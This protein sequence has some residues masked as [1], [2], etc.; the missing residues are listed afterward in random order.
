MESR[1]RRPRRLAPSFASQIARSITGSVIGSITTSITTVV[2]AP[3]TRAVAVAASLTALLLLGGAG[4]T[5]CSSRSRGAPAAAMKPDSAYADYWDARDAALAGC[6]QGDAAACLRAAFG[7]YA[8]GDADRW[9]VIRKGCELGE[10]LVCE[11]GCILGGPETNAGFVLA[12]HQPNADL[13]VCQELER[14][15]RD[16]ALPALQATCRQRQLLKPAA[17][18]D[19]IAQACAA[20]SSDERCQAA[21]ALREGSQ[22]PDEENRAGSPLRLRACQGGWPRACATELSLRCRRLYQTRDR[23]ELWAVEDRACTEEELARVAKTES[24]RAL[25]EET[26]RRCKG[27]EQEA[28]VSLPELPQASAAALCARGYRPACQRIIARAGAA[29]EQ[30]LGALTDPLSG[31]LAGA[32]AC[33]VGDKRACAD[34]HAELLRPF[35]GVEE[36]AEDPGFDEDDA[37]GSRR[38]ARR[39]ALPQNVAREQA[40]QL[41]LRLCGTAPWACSIAA[42]LT[43]ESWRERFIVVDGEPASC[44]QAISR[45]RQ[46][47]KLPP[48]AAGPELARA[49]AGCQRHL[50]EPHRTC[51]AR[52]ERMAELFN[53]QEALRPDEVLAA[54]AGRLALQAVEHFRSKRKLPAAWPGKAKREPCCGEACAPPPPPGPD[55]GEVV[56][57]NGDVGVTQGDAEGEAMAEHAATAGYFDR[58]APEEGW[59]APTPRS[60]SFGDDTVS[61]D[62]RYPWAQLLLAR[63]SD[64]VV[65]SARGRRTCD[66]PEVIVEERWRLIDGEPSRTKQ[67]R[68]TS[69]QPPR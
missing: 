44:E 57:E 60:Y 61:L 23:D 25:I 9:A 14:M 18:N 48:L 10:A 35:E 7:P 59:N 34:L 13:Y 67:T 32:P 30:I 63:E 53:C 31:P 62:E 1:G 12:C 43:S 22:A 19:V 29:P 39:A 16:A 40:N 20:S 46:L 55:F 54:E 58:D 69:Q 49:L 41:L 27:G 64:V 68:Q 4:L 33:L 52:A 38:R 3:V 45:A 11:S 47:A 17:W 8:L 15:N 50:R 66:E 36:P 51:L 24:G 5:G 28:C 2:T 6:L 65:V 21:L 26:R 56:D 37:D 42:A